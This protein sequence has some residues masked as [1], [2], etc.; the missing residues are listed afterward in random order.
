MVFKRW[1]KADVAKGRSKYGNKK[2]E[3]FGRVFDSKKE[4]DRFMVLREA[5][6]DGLI[7][8]LQ[9]QVKYEL[10]PPITEEYI[11]HLKTKDKVRR[12]TVQF[13]ITYTCDFQYKKNG[14][15]VVEDVKASK[16]LIAKE[17][18]IKAKLFRWKYGTS[19]RLVFKANDPI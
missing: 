13:A 4:K 11:E 17:F 12:R 9:C 2:V 3:A 6:A 8:D 15:M 16:S 5:E 1:N 14:E 10:I 18:A 19:I 7:T